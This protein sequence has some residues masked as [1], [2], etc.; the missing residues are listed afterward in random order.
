MV[1]NLSLSEPNQL[2]MILRSE[3]GHTVRPFEV[4]EKVFGLSREEIKQA[5]VVKQ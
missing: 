5:V 4:L 3:P 1:I 2:K